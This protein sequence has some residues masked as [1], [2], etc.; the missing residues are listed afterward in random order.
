MN[1]LAQVQLD[2]NRQNREGWQAFAGHRRKVTDLLTA[3]P[4]GGDSRLCILGA[5]NCNDLDLKL[6]QSA[7]REI[8]LV[9]LDAAALEEGLAR[10]GL[11]P[12]AAWQLHGGL[13]VTGMQ[14]AMELWTPESP[15][16][17]AE[18]AACLA[19]PAAQVGPALPGPF[20]AVAS[21]CLLS[22]ILNALPPA[23]G[24]AHPRFLDLLQALRLG[25]LRLLSGLLAP[26]G[27]GWL[28]TDVV[29]SDSSPELRS[30]ADEELPRLL[31]R[32]LHERNFF[33]G[34][35]PSVLLDVLR[36]DPVLGQ[37]IA[38]SEPV[39]P[40]RWDLGA[41]QYIVY[42]IKMRRR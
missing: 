2:F 31:T 20:A 8:H 23:V 41:R 32:L 18:L 29:S 3:E 6:L 28:I 30:T 38:A 35:N 12:D 39:G 11:R 37:E 25:H 16:G 9:D 15:L 10:Q 5:G 36:T 7:Y 42:A 24:E 1:R 21:T 4:S 33:H 40:W 22:Q 13:D 34:L 19:Q 14:A 27:A 26:G 17:D